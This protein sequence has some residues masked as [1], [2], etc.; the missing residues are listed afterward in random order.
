VKTIPSYVGISVKNQKK[1][2]KK[3]HK[4]TKN[5]IKKTQNKNKQK[6]NVMMQYMVDSGRYRQ[7]SDSGNDASRF[8]LLPKHKSTLDFF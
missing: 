6:W 5:K 4:Q 3:K 8:L 2:K 7:Q 1:K